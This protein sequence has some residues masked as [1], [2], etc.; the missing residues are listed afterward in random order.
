M[1]EAIHPSLRMDIITGQDIPSTNVKDDSNNNLTEVLKPPD[2]KCFIPNCNIPPGTE[3]E[4][5]ESGIY[6]QQADVTLA[7]LSNDVYLSRKKGYG[8]F[9]P[10]THDELIKN[11]IKPERLEDKSNGFRAALYTNG[12]Q[13]VLAFAGT[14]DGQDVITDICQAI[15]LKTSQYSQAVNIA[16][17][18]KK[19]FGDKLVVTGHSLGGG[20]ASVAA[21]ASRT[22]AVTFNAAG[23]A[24]NTIKRLKIDPFKARLS[25]SIGGIRSYNEKHDILTIAQEFLPLPKSVGCKVV[26][27]YP[28]DI[29]NAFKAH[30]I[31]RTSLSIWKNS[32]WKGRYV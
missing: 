28:N 5:I 13:V 6:P 21:L 26:V 15:G 14:N 12:Q 4:W 23:L 7:Q 3:F 29:V 31:D 32:P 10:F 24:D 17:T 8:S 22:F 1:T 25:A 30:S 18:T 2:G 9:R 27:E 20:L 19:V 16:R 11:G